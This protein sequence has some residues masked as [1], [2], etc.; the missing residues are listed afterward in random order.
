MTPMKFQCMIDPGSIDNA[1]VQMQR[2]VGKKKFRRIQKMLGGRRIWIPKLGS[3][4]KFLCTCCFQRDRCI[5]LMRR[6]GASVK[7][8]S[9]AYGLSEKRIYNIINSIHTARV[10]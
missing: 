7:Q 6:G 9:A 1:L 4:E 2:L 10:A 8:L 3:E 5:Q